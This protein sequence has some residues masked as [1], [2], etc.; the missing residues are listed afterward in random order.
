MDRAKRWWTMHSLGIAK[1]ERLLAALTAALVA[2]GLVAASLCLAPAALADDGPLLGAIGGTY[3][4]LSNNHIRMESET[5]QAICYRD[6]AEYR[7]DFLFVNSGPAE[8]VTLGFPFAADPADQSARPVAFRAW[9]DGDPLA[10][11][12]GSGAIDAYTDYYVHEAT[13]PRGKTMIR[14]SY[15][16][17][18]TESVDERFPEL[19][20]PQYA[21][22]NI[23][24]MAASYDYWL[25]TGAGW[26]GT[27]GTAVVR[28]TLADDFRGYGLDVTPGQQDEDQ[29]WS[30]LTTPAKYF[31]PDD[32]TYEWVFKSLEPTEKDD[33]ELGFT[34]L[35]SEGYL[36]E[37]PPIMGAV[38]TQVTSS[39]SPDPSAPEASYSADGDPESGIGLT[40]E[41]PW[42]R[43]EIN[44]DRQIR[45]MRIVTGDNSATDSF[46]KSGRPKTIRVTLSDGSTS[47]VKLADE[48]SVQKVPISGKADWAR[49]D[50]IDS[51]PGSQSTGIYIAEV[52][53]G[54]RPAPSFQAFDS[55]IEA[56]GSVTTSSTAHPASPSTVPSDTAS[57]TKP[58]AS[59][60]TIALALTTVSSTAATSPTTAS[61]AT[62]PSA[63]N[64]PVSIGLGNPAAAQGRARVWTVWPIVLVA[65]AGVALIVAAV[66]SLL[67]VSRRRR[68]PA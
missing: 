67:L 36:S 12:L 42:I 26:A 68:P 5:V 17:R 28:Y 4:P 52:S 43:M 57:T 19:M 40:G 24:P 58:V 53:F 38:V 1:A 20:P 61:S 11:K 10:V 15:L 48:P 66:L 23:Y 8:H 22:P 62:T 21:K 41:H 32:H 63:T 54:N 18:A 14:V 31:K 9:Q 55:L 51:Y 13:F 45:E 65:V 34:K 6:Y 56:A 49:L 33:V 46:G 37:I 59:S 39:N 44:G 7:V 47:T 16:A 30:A 50:V 35:S 60:A 3:Y 29:G 2:G 64:S 25:H 27:I